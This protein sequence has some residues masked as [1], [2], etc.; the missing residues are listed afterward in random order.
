[1]WPS[2]TS[3][4]LTLVGISSLGETPEWLPVLEKPDPPVNTVVNGCSFNFGW[5]IPLI[6]QDAACHSAQCWIW[7]EHGPTPC[8]VLSLGSSSPKS[9]KPMKRLC[10]PQNR[11]DPEGEDDGVAT[12]SLNALEPLLHHRP[13]TVP[14]QTRTEW[15]AGHGRGPPPRVTEPAGR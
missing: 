15:G 7:C 14:A 12:S 13:Q 2:Q 5:S 8:R 3:T 9:Q 10:S 6:A 11:E 4:V 1:M